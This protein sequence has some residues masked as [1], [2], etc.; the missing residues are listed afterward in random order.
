MTW[1]V[2]TDPMKYPIDENWLYLMKYYV[3]VRRKLLVGQVFCL[4]VG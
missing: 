2:I 3:N 1:V 4:Q